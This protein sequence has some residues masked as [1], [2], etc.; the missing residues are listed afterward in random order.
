MAQPLPAESAEEQAASA[1]NRAFSVRTLGQGVPFAAPGRPAEPQR[2][3]LNNPAQ[4]PQNPPPPAPAPAAADGSWGRPRQRRRPRR[5]PH[6]SSPPRRRRRSSQLPRPARPYR[7]RPP[8][9]TPTAIPRRAGR[10]R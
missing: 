6:R 9:R 7:R 10:T 8:R 2:R 3:P 1:Q 5:L 4:P